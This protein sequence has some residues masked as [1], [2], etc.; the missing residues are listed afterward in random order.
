MLG[1]HDEGALFI[2]RAAGH[3][4][5][6]PFLYRK[7]LARQH[8]FVESGPAFHDR[9]I[10]RHSLTRFD[11]KAVARAHEIKG[12]SALPAIINE[13]RSLG[14]KIEQGANG[15]TCLFT[16]AEFKQL[17]E[18]DKREDDRRRHEIKADHT[19]QEKK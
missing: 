15:R 2:D 3:W 4:I 7:R 10:N 18:Q 6:R 5:T 14:R 11:A 19:M 13:V 16:R 1:G 9:T 12:D 8:R 17:T